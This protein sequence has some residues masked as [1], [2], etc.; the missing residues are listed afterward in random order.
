VLAGDS[1]YNFR[2]TEKI[3]HARLQHIDSRMAVDPQSH[4]IDRQ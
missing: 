2:L 1:E 4:S 3:N